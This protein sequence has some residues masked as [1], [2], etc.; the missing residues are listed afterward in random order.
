[1]TG[2]I[3]VVV[4]ATVVVVDVDVVVVVL[5]VVGGTVLFETDIATE[6]STSMATTSAGE[7]PHDT[8][9]NNIEKAKLGA[10]NRERRGFT[11]K[12]YAGPQQEC[13]PNPFSGANGMSDGSF[14][15]E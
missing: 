15:R 9:T 1:M 6:L 2:A 8:T 13:E 12:D 14:R 11:A 3:D 4:V 10:I 7:E 5:V